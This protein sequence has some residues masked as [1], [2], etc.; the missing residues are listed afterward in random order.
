LVVASKA[1]PYEYDD[2]YQRQNQ[3]RKVRKK[4]QFSLHQATTNL[5]VEL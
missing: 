5:K 2:G 4:P 1:D 3:Q